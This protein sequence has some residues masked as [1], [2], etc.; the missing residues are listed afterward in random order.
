M[1]MPAKALWVAAIPN[2]SIHMIRNGLRTSR[3]H[4]TAPACFSEGDVVSCVTTLVST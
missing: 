1:A 2:V 3:K 4:C